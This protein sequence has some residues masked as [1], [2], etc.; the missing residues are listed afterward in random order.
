MS[1]YPY[2]CLFSLLLAIIRNFIFILYAYLR[3]SITVRNRSL[4]RNFVTSP[5]TEILDHAREL[6]RSTLSKV[7]VAA[8]NGKSK[9]YRLSLSSAQWKRGGSSSARYCMRSYVRSRASLVAKDRWKGSKEGGI[10]NT[11][12]KSGIPVQ[13]LAKRSQ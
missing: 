6:N 11:A 8:D 4:F 9:S 10:C 2:L 7:A 12:E 5:G 13:L 1:C 3:I